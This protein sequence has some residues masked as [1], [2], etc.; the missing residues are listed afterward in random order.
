MAAFAKSSQSI[1][2]THQSQYRGH[3][4]VLHITIHKQKGPDR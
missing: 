2:S 3:D 1:R 4:S